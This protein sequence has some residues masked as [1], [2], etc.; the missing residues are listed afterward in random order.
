MQR[1]RFLQG[2]LGGGIGAGMLLNTASA[3]SGPTYITLEW[4][5]CR[6][7]QDVQRLR[8]FLGDALVPAYNRAGGKPVG[9]LQTSIGP[10]TPS[11]LVVT[12]HISMAAIQDAAQKLQRDEQWNIA[13]L[14]LD[15]NWELSYDRR[16]SSLLRG[17][18]NFPRIEVPKLSDPTKTNLF[19]L[20]IYESRN[21]NGHLRKVAMFDKGEIDVFRK[22]GIQPVF[23]GTTVFGRDMPNL[24]Y[25]VYY[26]TW[27]ARRE[28]WMKFGEDPDWK[29]MSTA[30]G[31]ADRELVSRI[32]NQLMTPL[33]GSQLK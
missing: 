14:K 8:T 2:A 31:N 4:F 7:D 30:P 17:F 9:L 24:V 18:R 28:A 1:R 5:R 27:E 33:P 20:R 26:P 10:D 29:K 23:F 12:Q 13:S 22:V 15:E 25:M 32:S 6:R 19:E 11:F 3:Q 16:E 21:M